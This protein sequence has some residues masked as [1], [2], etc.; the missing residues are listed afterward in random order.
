[1]SIRGLR[2]SDPFQIQA[3]TGVSCVILTMADVDVGQCADG[4]EFSIH[5]AFH[6][7]PHAP[8]TP[9]YMHGY[10]CYIYVILFVVVATLTSASGL[11]GPGLLNSYQASFA[12]VLRPQH[13][14]CCGYGSWHA[15]HLHR[16]DAGRATSFPL[17]L[18]PAHAP[19]TTP[20]CTSYMSNRQTRLPSD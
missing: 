3:S 20:W 1:M 15:S 4:M 11:V 16:T 14:S 18:S 8:V 10:C 17:L 6:S 2:S 9:C 13:R 7:W 5:R 12:T 19:A